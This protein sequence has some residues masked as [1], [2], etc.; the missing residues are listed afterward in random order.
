MNTVVESCEEKLIYGLSIY[1]K[2]VRI[3]EKCARYM[4]L[5]FWKDMILYDGSKFT[6]F[7]KKWYR[8]VNC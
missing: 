1:V 5:E 7:G 2:K 8:K 4:S 3:L 6:I